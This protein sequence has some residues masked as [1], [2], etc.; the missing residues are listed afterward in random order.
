MKLGSILR[1]EP[2][3]THFEFDRKQVPNGWIV[4]VVAVDGMVHPIGVTF[5]PDPDHSW[6]GLELQETS[7]PVQ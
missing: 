3:R 4:T 1:D 7:G 6:L 2:E 5:V